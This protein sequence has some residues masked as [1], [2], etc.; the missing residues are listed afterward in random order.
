MKKQETVTKTKDS[1]SDN[2]MD[3]QEAAK[4]SRPSQEDPDL[5]PDGGLKA[6]SVVFGSFLCCITIFGLMNAMGAIESYVQVNQLADVAV[7][8]ISWV[9]SL[10]VFMTLVMGLVAGPLYDTFGS[11]VLLSI[12]S[13]LAFVGLMALASSTQLYQFI[14]SF[15]ICT[16]IGCGFMMFPAVS[17]V[18]SWFLKKRALVIGLATGG[19]C[20]GGMIFPILLRFMYA[21][22]GFVWAQ[23]TLAFI[24]LGIDAIGILL[25]KDRLKELHTQTG[26][27][28]TR[29][30]KQKL[31]GSIDFHAFKEAQFMVLSMGLFMN[32]ITVIVPLTYISSYAM[33]RGVTR[34][35]SYN[36]ITILN[37]AG[38]VG[39]FVPSYYAD[40]YGSF[41]MICLMSF[42]ITIAY[43]VIW[44]PF[45]YSKAALYVFS[46]VFG[47]CFA[48]TYALSGSSISTITKK[49]SDF[50]KRYGSAYFIIAF[51]NIVSLPIAGA[52]LKHKTIEEY[53]HMVYFGAATATVATLLLVAA[54]YTIVG[55]KIRTII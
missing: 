18:S 24:N 29:T 26:H 46:V 47:F 39:K 33:A 52:L 37:A 15:G 12:G 8:K 54:R 20:V 6:Y 45:G 41:N 5:F 28:D 27:T 35:E 14:L 34:E 23:R 22:Y 3:R 13:L 2:T 50:G 19:G 48:A 17:C 51:G 38:T 7:T 1:V 32:E 40:Y 44:V 43:W 42:G 49:T 25:A 4:D 10:N 11:T 9:F 16:G 21:R 55:F 30:F 31:H 36:M 53:C